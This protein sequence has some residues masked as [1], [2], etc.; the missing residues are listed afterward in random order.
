VE[1]HVEGRCAGRLAAEPQ[2]GT[3]FGYDP[4]FMPDGL[5]ATFAEISE[6]EKNRLS[7]RGRA[8]EQFVSWWKTKP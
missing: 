1:N 6:Q 8:W 3:G 5:Q 7:H 2:G 4:L